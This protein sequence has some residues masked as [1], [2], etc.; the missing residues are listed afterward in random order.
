MFTT[1]NQT[2]VRSQNTLNLYRL[3]A[4]LDAEQTAALLGLAP[5]ETPFLVRA[6]LLHPLGK[7]VQNSRKFFAAS[8]V[9][10]LIG[11]QSLDPATKA[12]QKVI[13]D[14]NATRHH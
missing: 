9:Q 1:Q 12:I 8:E 11:R 14:G 3:P 10:E 5:Y 4:R 13:E 7:P 6:K 2:N